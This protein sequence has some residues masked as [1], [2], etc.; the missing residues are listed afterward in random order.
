MFFSCTVKEKEILSL[1]DG[2][3]IIQGKIISFF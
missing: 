1:K 3:L 2:S